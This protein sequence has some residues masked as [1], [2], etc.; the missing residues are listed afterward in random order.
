MAKESMKAR[1]VKRAK[2]VEK[3][4]AKRAKLKEEGDYAA[5]SLLPRNS[6]PIRLHN[7]CKLTWTSQRLYETIWYQPYPIP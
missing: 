3:Y 4:A 5:L 1:E 6:N 7:R 2:L